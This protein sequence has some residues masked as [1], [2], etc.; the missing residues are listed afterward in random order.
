M[1]ATSQKSTPAETNPLSID[2]IGQRI[3]LIRGQRVLLDSDLAALYGVE[4]RRLNEQ[5]RRNRDRFPAD[6]IYEVTTMEFANLKSQIAISSL[7]GSESRHG[8]RRKLPLAFTEHGAIMAA[9]ILSSPRAVAMSVHVVRSFV[10]I[11]TLSTT[12]QELTKRLNTME[13]KHDSFS[14]QTR[15]ELKEVFDTLRELMAP[16]AEPIPPKR[17][18][19]FITDDAPLPKPKPKA[20]KD[21][22]AK[23]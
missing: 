5:V 6:F 7:A 22:T 13:I 18:I 1:T 8:G 3:Q 11:R 2:E 19:G 10:E 15:A 20:V 9:T 23:G 21:R 4:T 17:Q 12:H 16:P 14:R